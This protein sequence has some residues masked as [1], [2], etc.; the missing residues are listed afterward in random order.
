[1][2]SSLHKLRVSTFVIILLELLI[3]GL[4]VIFYF[5]D[6]PNGFKAFM[7]TE[8][9]LIAMA[10]IFS[11]NLLF[12]W[13]SEAHIGTIRKKNDV[14]ASSI[15]GGDVQEAYRFGGLGM[16]LTDD[17][18]V[19]IWANSLFKERNIDVLDQNILQWQPA[20]TELKTSPSETSVKVE[21]GTRTY[22]A[23]YL[24][25]ANIYIFHDTTDY[26]SVSAYLK[27]Q[28]LVLG[29]ITIDNYGDIAG[30]VEEDNNDLITKVRS[31]IFDYCKKFNVLLRKYRSDSY[32]AVCNYA[33][34]EAMEKDGFTLFDNVHA[35][36]KGSNVLPTLSIG[37]SHAAPDA[38]KLN[39][40]A[41]NA[42]DIAMS[43][44]GDQ[45]VV[46]HYGEDLKFYGGK[47]AA[48]ENT[49]RVQFRSFADS[50]L[51][52]ISSATDVIVSGH[53]DMD[54][55][56]LGSCLGVKAI[57]DHLHKPCHIV[58]DPR[59]T[60]KKTRYAFEGS[61][62]KEELAAMT[63]TPKEASDKI[64]PSTIFVVVDVSV[65]AMIMGSKALNLATKTIVIDHHR[66]GEQFVERPV[67]Q[68][69]DPSASS[70]CELLAEFIHYA[71]ANPR[72]EIPPAYATL[73]LS[74]I[75][76]DT[77]FFKAKSTGI[78][79][80]EAAEIL[81]EYKA[82]NAI[83]DDFLKDDYE[84]YVLLNSIVSTMKV[85]YPGIVYCV[86]EDRDIVERA[87]LS[88]VANRLMQLKDINAAFVIG[89]TQEEEIRISARSDGTINVQLLCEKM[90]SGGG[91]FAMAAAQFVGSST[92]AV[93]DRLKETLDNY[94]A[95]AS[96]NIGGR[97]Q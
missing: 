42:I 15:L 37:F 92:T 16:V 72:I 11:F 64:K 97:N 88:K 47:T 49:G 32:F 10:V 76:L 80:F 30:D 90:G 59:L 62:S 20:L 9:W 66:R 34:L 51:G 2:S 36:G 77:N 93:V 81:K 74:G 13:F 57:C 19:V 79:T 91:H 63:I 3:V 55:D 82:D 14:A 86:S 18:D 71:T 44:G 35:V 95:E 69:V 6:I 89:R 33:S 46:S 41:S 73:M 5:Y 1:M 94:L 7:K 26:D 31:A 27:E 85:P 84:E 50:L 67:L 56:A 23:R 17:H 96:S 29:I 45:A 54:M 21:F 61:F 52:L 24:S 48:L 25:N 38:S 28:G 43:R 4:A 58:Y 70:A 68:Y 53:T 8:Y 60:E 75:F 12:V 65:P 22:A 83:A 39:E 87:T 40:M 78:R